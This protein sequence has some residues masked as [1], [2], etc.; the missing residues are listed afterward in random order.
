M[1]G[2]LSNVWGVAWRVDLFWGLVWA[3][4]GA[5]GEGIAFEFGSGFGFTPAIAALTVAL[6][7]GLMVLRSTAAA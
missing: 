6:V 5:K 7:R 3:T 2:V 4:D 1:L